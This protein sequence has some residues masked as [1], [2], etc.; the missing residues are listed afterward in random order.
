MQRHMCD[1]EAA[2]LS[3]ARTGFLALGIDTEKRKPTTTPLDL[4]AAFERSRK[5]GHVQEQRA[6]SSLKVRDLRALRLC[7]DPAER[8]ALLSKKLELLC[9]HVG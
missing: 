4:L 5:H 9:Q 7:D 6:L 3:T 1:Q 8:L 2:D